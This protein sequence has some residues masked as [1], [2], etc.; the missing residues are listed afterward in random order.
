VIAGF[1]QDDYLPCLRSYHIDG[2]ALGQAI[3]SDYVSADLSHR[4]DDRAYVAA[5]AQPDFTRMFMEG[6]HPQYEVF[7]EAYIQ[8]VIDRFGDVVKHSS[9]DAKL[10][11][12]VDQAQ[13][14]LREQYAEELEQQRYTAYVEPVLD[15]VGSLPKDELG[16]LAES[17]VNLTVLKKRVSHEDETVGGPVDVA[18]ISKGDGLIWVRRKHYFDPALNQHFFANYFRRVSNAKE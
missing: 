12:A 15:A 16:A 4:P 17:L 14:E 3:Y 11:E 7:V 1:G 5:F 9:D 8:R 6:V 2:V 18:V 13:E 10:A